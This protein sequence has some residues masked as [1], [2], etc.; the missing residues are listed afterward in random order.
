MGLTG[1]IGSGKS[2]VGEY[3]AQLGAQVIDADDLARGAIERGSDGFDEVVAAFGD[4]ILKNGDID[5]Q[6]LAEKIFGSQENK[7]IL[8]SIIHPR[9]R[10]GFA[11][12]ANSLNDDEIMIYEIPLLAETGAENQFDYVI[13]VE[14]LIENRFGRLKVRGMSRSDVE[15]R[16]A[17]QASPEDRRAISDLIIENNGTPEELFNEVER[18]WSEVLPKIVGK[19]R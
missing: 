12:A 14:S 5:R 11:L 10:A 17:V 16:I 9:V 15:A 1:G 13:T 6:V 2:L 18:I 7:M 3:F 4:S 19:Q 8:E